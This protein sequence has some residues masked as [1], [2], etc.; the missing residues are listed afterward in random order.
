MAVEVLTMD[1]DEGEAAGDRD[2][3]PIDS[4]HPD[5]LDLKLCNCA[6][7][8]IEIL[9]ESNL[10]WWKRLPKLLRQRYQPMVDVRMGGRPYCKFCARLMGLRNRSRE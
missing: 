3:I 7:C 4:P 8:G 2:V 5:S 9:G 1:L 10:P 6:R